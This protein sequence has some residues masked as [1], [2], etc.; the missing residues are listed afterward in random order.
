MVQR[1]GAFVVPALKESFQGI[2]VKV[3]FRSANKPFLAMQIFVDQPRFYAR[4]Y[5]VAI[6]DGECEI[7]IKQ[8]EFAPE[9]KVGEILST[10]MPSTLQNDHI[11]WVQSPRGVRFETYAGN[12]S[13]F[14]VGKQEPSTAQLC[15]WLQ[16]DKR[17]VIAHFLLVSRHLPEAV[18]ECEPTSTACQ[19]QYAG[20]TAD[21]S[22]FKPPR[23]FGKNGEFDVQADYGDVK[24]QQRKLSEFWAKKIEA[25]G[26]K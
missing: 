26:A 12:D 8:S 22:H 4:G 16:D 17:W 15:E 7:A 10:K 11:L 14:G 13:Y 20:L 2:K 6:G 23:A 24:A 19:V 9:L 25:G 1:R 18:V 21:L 3:K 5:V